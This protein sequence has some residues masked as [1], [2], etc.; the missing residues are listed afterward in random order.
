MHGCNCIL[1]DGPTRC[2]ECMSLLVGLHISHRYQNVQEPLM[3]ATSG[4]A[5]AA[6][7]DG[8]GSDAN[9]DGANPFAALFGQAVRP[10]A[11]AQW[12]RCLKHPV[13]CHSGWSQS[14]FRSS[15]GCWH[16]N[17]RRTAQPMGTG[18]CSTSCGSKSCC[19]RRRNA[20]SSADDGCNGRCRCWRDGR[21]GRDGRNGRNGR[22][23]RDGRNASR[24]DTGDAEP[25]DAEPNGPHRPTPPSLKR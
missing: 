20:R 21:D 11:F 1:F 22:N 14:E 18:S 17:N 13:M 7:G 3:D 23:G 4:S 5:Q 2:E 16:T 12:L 19:T 15:T 9:A 24:D 25:D 6:F 8:A 10:Q